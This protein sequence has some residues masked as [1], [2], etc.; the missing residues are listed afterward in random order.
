MYHIISYHIISY[1]II[2]YHIIS[3]HI[4]SYHIISYHII[5]YHIISYHIISYHII[6]YQ[7]HHKNAY[8]CVCVGAI[9]TET[10]HTGSA[11]TVQMLLGGTVVQLLA[12]VTR[13]WAFI[14]PK[15]NRVFIQEPAAFRCQPELSL[16]GA[17][18]AVHM[19]RC[20]TSLQVSSGLKHQG[21]DSYLK[22]KKDVE[23]FGFPHRCTGVLISP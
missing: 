20:C 15:P 6:S 10:T 21:S 12:I 17:Y 13:P 14:S 1:H 19:T 16:R 22:K 5:S 23:F 3:Y 9:M 8:V 2:S 11:G 7:S 18:S 4:I